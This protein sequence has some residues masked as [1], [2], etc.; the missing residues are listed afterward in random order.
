MDGPFYT[1]KEM[2]PYFRNQ[3]KKDQ[4]LAP[5]F[6]QRLEE[7]DVLDSQIAGMSPEDQDRWLAQ[8]E[9]IIQH[10]ASHEL[11]A[12]CLKTVAKVKSP[13][14][15]QALNRASA[16]A[17]EKVRIAACKAW[18]VQQDQAAKEMLLSLANSDKSVSVRAAAIRELGAF[19]D[20][21][22]RRGLGV[23]MD[24]RS[25]AI[26]YEVAQSLK[27]QT[28][29]DYGGD[30]ESWKRFLNGEDVPEPTPTTIADRAMQALTPWRK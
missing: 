28:G 23:M 21:D 5:T 11:R 29:R 22:V 26:Q 10:D 6:T 15:T 7:L 24:D 14:A 17:N 25:T 3:W 13:A 1:M 9:G 27:R 8:L 18:G 16:D 12:R 20:P 2:N 19:D 30:F 4:S